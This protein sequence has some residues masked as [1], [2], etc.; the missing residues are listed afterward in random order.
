[1]VVLAIVVGEMS[2][3]LV[4][5]PWKEFWGIFS[6]WS[7][8]KVDVVWN[9]QMK[10]PWKWRFWSRYRRSWQS[11]MSREE[12]VCLWGAQSRTGLQICTFLFQQCNWVLGSGLERT[13]I[14]S[15]Q[16]YLC[17]IHFPNLFQFNRVIVLYTYSTNVILVRK[18]GQFS[19]ERINN[20]IY[21]EFW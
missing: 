9:T 21:R 8:K 13:C 20:C 7:I 5:H 19:S 14:S 11:R 4:Q 12:K 17:I 16:F 15:I 10:V 18:T 2:W 6:P 3:I 1:M